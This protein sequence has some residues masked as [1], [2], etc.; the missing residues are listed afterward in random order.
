MS[1]IITITL[2]ILAMLFSL[3]LAGA[4]S[5]AAHLGDERV[6]L[7]AFLIAILLGLTGLRLAGLS[8]CK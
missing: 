6:F 5:R 4:A 8:G 2:S 3:L 1:K 7:M